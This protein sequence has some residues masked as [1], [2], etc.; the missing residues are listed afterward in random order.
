MKR[1]ERKSGEGKGGAALSPPQTTAF[2]D[3]VNGFLP[4]FP[5]AELGPR[6]KELR[7]ESL[8][9]LRRKNNS[10]SFAEFRSHNMPCDTDA[11]LL[12]MSYQTGWD[13]PDLLNGEYFE[14]SGL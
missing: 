1:A 3:P 4:F 13:F 6:L 8:S 14:D 11:L 10:Q 7:K 12:Q 5:T 9:C 2:L